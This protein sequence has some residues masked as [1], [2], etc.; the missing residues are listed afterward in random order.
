MENSTSNNIE[1][2]NVQGTNTSNTG[3]IKKWQVNTI[4]ILGLLLLVTL[5]LLFYVIAFKKPSN[6]AFASLKITTKKT[7]TVVNPYKGWLTYTNPT[8]GYSFKYP[9]SWKLNTQKYQVTAT[10]P[11]GYKFEYAET[12]GPVGGPGVSILAKSSVININNT[13][14]Y[15]Y[16][17]NQSIQGCGYQMPTYLFVVPNG[18]VTSFSVID[19]GQNV[20]STT[21]DKTGKTFNGGGGLIYLNKNTIA[22]IF[23]LPKT[24]PISDASPSS[25]SPFEIVNNNLNLILKSIKF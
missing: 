17:I 3:G 15:K 10:S 7:N 12:S 2:P 9:P 19:V 14:Y 25:S 16:Y 5:G 11:S 13:K 23:T 20:P 1:T 22:I 18:C 21:T 4:I 8:Y 6:N 24:L